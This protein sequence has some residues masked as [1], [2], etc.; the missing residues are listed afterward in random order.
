VLLQPDLIVAIDPGTKLGWSVFSRSE[1]SYVL[2]AS[3]VIDFTGKCWGERFDGT[4]EFIHNK[5]L[6]IMQP[7]DK[8]AVVY[9]NIQARTLR[10]WDNLRVTTGIITGIYQGAHRAGIPEEQIFPVPLASVKLFATGDGKASKKQMRD[11]FITKYGRQP[12]TDDEADAAHIGAYCGSVLLDETKRPNTTVWKRIAAF[13]EGGDKPV[14]KKRSPR[15]K[16]APKPRP[17][18]G[19]SGGKRVKASTKSKP[20]R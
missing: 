9:E 17:K 2:D 15:K 13:Y 16:K 1:N 5:I 6:S 10:S 11:A 14:V 18:K 3:G 20:R 7:L 12:K 8:V 19:S 4:A